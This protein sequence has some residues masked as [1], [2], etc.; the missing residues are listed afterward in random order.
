MTSAPICV[1]VGCG[2][3]VRRSS[4]DPKPIGVSGKALWGCHWVV[5]AQFGGENT[6]LKRKP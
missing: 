4:L 2:T 3:T 6:G 1:K 5:G